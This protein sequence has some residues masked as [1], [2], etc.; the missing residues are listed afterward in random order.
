MSLLG[1]RFDGQHNDN[2]NRNKYV[3]IDVWAHVP[4]PITPVMITPTK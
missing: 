4:T 3:T 2:D 1:L